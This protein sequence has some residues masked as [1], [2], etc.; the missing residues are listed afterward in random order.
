M[1]PEL[2]W[3]QNQ[4]NILQLNYRP[5][6]RKN[7]NAKTTSKILENQSPQIKITCYN[8]VSFTPGM[9]GWFNT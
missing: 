2:S 8:Q 5:K 3:H 9:W 4:S 6:Y 1:V 7:I